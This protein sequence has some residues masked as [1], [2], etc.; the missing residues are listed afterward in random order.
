MM[1]VGVMPVVA[2][3]VCSVADGPGSGGWAREFRS[4]GALHGV[5]AL[6]F[7]GTIV[8]ACVLGRWL[9]RRDRE[10]ALRVGWLLFMLGWQCWTVVFF[11]L[12]GVYHPAVSLPLHVCDLVPWVGMIALLTQHPLFRAVLFYWGIGL[13][14]QAFFTP[15]LQEGV[16]DWNYWLFWVG[17]TQI[18]GSA[19]Y[20]L[21]VLRFRPAWRDFGLG[22]FFTI[23]YAALVSAINIPNGWNY[24]YI[25]DASP[26]RPTIIDRLGP[27]PLR[28]GWLGVIVVAMFAA[29]TAGVRVWVR[30]ASRARLD[31]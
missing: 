12:P 3:W 23:G 20:D 15:V 24:G 28:V 9:Q 19:V 6:G 29:M 8:G 21:V 25:G 17:H 13:S 1:V 10:F 5:T 14:T 22:L 18:V 30:F 11:L 4:F 31:R 27:W 16:A 7:L 26:E 2:A